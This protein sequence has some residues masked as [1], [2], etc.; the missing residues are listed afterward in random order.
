MKI[1]SHR[2]NLFGPQ[3]AKYGENHPSSI[4]EAIRLG[5]N[6]EID[7]WCIEGKLSLGHDKGEYVIDSRFLENDKLWIHAKNFYALYNLIHDSEKDVFYHNNEDYV[8]TSKKH[9]W[10]YPNSK[11]ELSYLSVAVLPELVK[12]WKG[13]DNCHGICTDYPEKHRAD[14]GYMY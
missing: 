10:T 4:L 6:V 8:L 1:I 14:I 13:L 5:F 7:V 3:T 11:L 2:G 9:I 12:D